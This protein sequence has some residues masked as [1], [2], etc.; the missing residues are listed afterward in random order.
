MSIEGILAN[1]VGDSFTK[2]ITPA[3][4]IVAEWIN[5]DTGVG[6]FIAFGN[7]MLK[8][9]WADLVSTPI[10]IKIIPVDINIE[11]SG[12]IVESNKIKLSDPNLD[13]IIIIPDKKNKSPTLVIQKAIVEDLIASSSLFQNPIRKYDAKPRNS[14]KIK[15]PSK[16]FEMT[17]KNIAVIKIVRKRKYLLYLA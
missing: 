7:H 15:L 5:A 4:T 12:R 13:T 14:Q 11:F 3:T 10:I 6:P 9:N 8:G 16:S 1:N 2:R 17:N